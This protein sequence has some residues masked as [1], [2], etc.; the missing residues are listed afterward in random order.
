MRPPIDYHGEMDRVDP[1]L[2][3]AALEGR[4]TGEPALDRAAQLVADLRR[5]L[6]EEPLP[7]AA[8]G[9]LEAMS[10]AAGDEARGSTPVLS[11]RR[12]AR[13]RRLASMPLAAVL[14][15]GA[16]LAWGAVTHPHQASDVAEEAVAAAQERANGGAETE[17]AET[18][19]EGTEGA[20][21]GQEVSEVA[22]DDSLQGCEKG[23]AVSDVASS[24]GNKQGP[25]QDPCSKGDENGA[26]GQEASAKGKQTAED[27]KAKA[28]GT[29]GGPPQDDGPPEEV[30]P[31]E[32]AGTQGK[33]KS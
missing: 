19:D 6:L 8:A 2:V 11:R 14:V 24:K 9:H 26:R 12:A 27:A 7:E 4:E 5:V 33:G 29:G 20:T 25:K 17:D 3:D 10:A 16:G 18:E 23:M 21:H 30:G 28:K 15:L 32:G 13:R 22:Q 31:P 1:R